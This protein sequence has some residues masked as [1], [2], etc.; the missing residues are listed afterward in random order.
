MD[1]EIEIKAFSEIQKKINSL[2]GSERGAY[3]HGWFDCLYFVMEIL[4]LDK[5]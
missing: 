4:K 1:K 5:S 3:M 2:H